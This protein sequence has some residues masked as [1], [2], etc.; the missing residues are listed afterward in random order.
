MTVYT[1]ALPKGGTGRTTTAAELVAHLA[2]AGRRVLAIDLDQQG[3]LSTR[4]GFTSDT[5][6]NGTAADVLTADATATEAATPAPAV[7]GVHALVGT[8]ELI[9]VDD[10]PPADLVTSLRDHLPTVTG[11]TGPW[12]DV[13]IDLALA[14]SR[15]ALAALAAADVVIAPVAASM[16]SLAQLPR[17]E[18]TIRDLTRRVRP[19]LALSWVVPTRADHRRLLTRDVLE[20]LHETYPGQVTGPVR[21]AVA[22]A[23]A[24]TA[25]LPVSLYRPGSAVAADYT[26]ALE[27]ITGHHLDSQAAQQHE[28]QQA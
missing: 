26:A 23:D 19:G 21:E 11:P 15:T 10:N 8:T 22:V 17:L 27:Q 14:M 28:G 16:E 20:A 25:G 3:N 7:A 12:D 24:F 5:E 13:V 6:V 9:A 1:L 18:G 2:A 4:L